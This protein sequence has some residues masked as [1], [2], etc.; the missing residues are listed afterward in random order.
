MYLIIIV[1]RDDVMQFVSKVYF[2]RCERN[3]F[4]CLSEKLKVVRMN[5]GRQ[6][7]PTI[8]RSKFFDLNQ[9][10]AFNILTYKILEKG[11]MFTSSTISKSIT[12]FLDELVKISISSPKD[13]RL[14]DTPNALNSA[15]V[16]KANLQL[17]E[18]VL[19]P[20]PIKLIWA[21]KR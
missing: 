8:L 11:V 13:A 6:K 15:K 1:T 20:D 12:H 7:R 17:S 5:Y 3:F 19:S 14:G 9:K 21:F 10:C 18:K 16:D 2:S 4:H